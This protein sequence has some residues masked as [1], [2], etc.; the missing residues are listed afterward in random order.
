MGV[1]PAPSP[2]WSILSR[3]GID[4][5]PLRTGPTWTDF[6]RSQACYL[7]A[8]D[9]FTVDTVLLRSRVRARAVR[10]SNAMG[11]SCKAIA[12]SPSKLAVIPLGGPVA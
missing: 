1:V 4:P 9:I 12:G 5:S 2:V 10:S 6:L 3:R 8:C 7:L 11:P